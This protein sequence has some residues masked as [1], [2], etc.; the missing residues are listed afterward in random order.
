MQVLM[1]DLVLPDTPIT[2]YNTRYSGITAAMMAGVTRT[3]ADA[4]RS[5]FSYMGPDT[6]LVSRLAAARGPKPEPLRDVQRSLPATRER[7]ALLIHHAGSLGILCNLVQH[8]TDSLQCAAWI[9]RIRCAGAVC[10]QSR[11]ARGSEDTLAQH[12]AKA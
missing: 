7:N 4:Q 2:D 11:S 3:L 10:W 12:A 1:D 8:H 9:G 6:L 5:L